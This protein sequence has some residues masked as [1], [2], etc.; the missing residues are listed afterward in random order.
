MIYISGKITDSDPEVQKK[1]MARFFEVEKEFNLKGE[2]CLNPAKQGDSPDKTY[3][4][5]LVDDLITIWLE[6]PE[7]YFMKGWQESRG[8]RLEHELAQRLGLH[9][10]YEE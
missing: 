3:E 5:Y 2:K 8:A 1:N 4:Y 6:L 10:D 7:M 9:C